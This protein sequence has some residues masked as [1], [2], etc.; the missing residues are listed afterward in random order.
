VSLD[1]K[2]EEVLAPLK[3]AEDA[4]APRRLHV[5]RERI[6]SHMVET[7]LA[8]DQRFGR[9]ARTFAALAL[10]ATF[11]LAS[12][13]GVSLYRRSV[14]RARAIEVMALRGTVTGVSGSTATGLQAGETSALE[15]AGTLETK[16]GGEARIKS[17]GLEITLFGNTKVSLSG[18]H[19][20]S[21]SPAL[22]LE[23]G[24]VRC[25]IAHQPG[26]TFSVVTAAARVV[27]V[28]TTFSVSVTPSPGGPTTVV[29]VEEGEVLVQSAGGERRLRAAESWSSVGEPPAAAVAP[30]PSESAPS[31]PEPAAVSPSPRRELPKRHS[32][33]L[34]AETKLLRSGLASEQRGDFVAAAAAFRTLIARYPESQLA[35]DAR[36]AL[37][38]VMVRQESSK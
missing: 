31:A 8:P 7:A 10:A 9:R 2:V 24:R 1:P 17:A 5:N 29:D 26:R 22:R 30:A 27:D 3:Q 37:Q 28:G 23:Q 6:I 20:N 33:T 38:R 16:D 18:L 36:A 12:W 34:V 13:G 4:L 15:P 21:T 32:E 11:L 25:V 19:A 35:P 14:A